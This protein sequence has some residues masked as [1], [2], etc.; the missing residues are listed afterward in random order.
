MEA[1]VVIG[2]AAAGYMIGSL[3]FARIVGRR[4]VPEADLTSTDVQ[5]PGG[6]TIEYT[7]VSATSIGARTGPK[8]ALVAGFADMAKAFLPTLGVRM[9]WPDDPYHLVVA[10]LVVVGHN[11]PV[12]HRFKGGR[13]QNALIG[14]LLAIDWLALPV[15][16]A[17]GIG[18]G[19]FVVRDMLVAYGLGQWL[20][21]P[22]FVWRGGAPATST[23]VPTNR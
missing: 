23:I 6:A 7:G 1:G 15:T 12:Y 4:V 17:L 22:W 2:L 8:W 19:L 20:L 18:I 3:S 16:T 13:G 9:A 11:Y 21:V 10:V 5:L 14:G